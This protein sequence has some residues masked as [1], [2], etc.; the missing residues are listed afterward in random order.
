MPR[1]AGCIAQFRAHYRCLNCEKNT[2][3]MIN[4]PDAEDAPCDIDEL[5]E[6]A[7]F[8][9]LRFRCQVCEGFIGQVIAIKQIY[10]EVPA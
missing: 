7:F 6:S 1:P 8:Q 9:S 4:V 2:S 10:D 5:V 3:Q